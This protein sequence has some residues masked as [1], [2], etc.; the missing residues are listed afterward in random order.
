[1][2]I[3]I[4]IYVL[5]SDKRFPMPCHTLSIQVCRSTFCKCKHVRWKV[6]KL[7]RMCN[8]KK[9]RELSKEHKLKTSNTH[10][11]SDDGGLSDWA[12]KLW[13]R[14]FLAVSELL[15]QGETPEMSRNHILFQLNLGPCCHQFNMGPNHCLY[16][17]KALKLQQ[18]HNLTRSMVQWGHFRIRVG[19]LLH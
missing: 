14:E 2:Y 19:Q 10:I 4:F 5:F 9:A 15:L 12:I 7:L 18:Q 1:M 6:E 17:V 16:V 3:I 11:P 8:K 13:I